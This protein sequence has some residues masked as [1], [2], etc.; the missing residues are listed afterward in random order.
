MQEVTFKNFTTEYKLI[1]Q[2]TRTLLV[3]TV[4]LVF[5]PLYPLMPGVGGDYSWM[6]GM[7]Q[8]VVEKF[9]F[10]KD[11]VFPLGPYASVYTKTYHPGTDHL[12]LLGGLILGIFNSII[13]LKLTKHKSI[14]WHI[15]FIAFFSAGM[16]SRDVLLFMYPLLL[17]L[18]IFEIT[19]LHNNAPRL[20]FQAKV[21][22][23]FLFIPLGLL[24]LIKGSLLVLILG[25]TGMTALLFWI[26]NMKKLA[27]TICVIPVLS[28][29]FFAWVAKQPI[30]GLFYYIK[31]MLDVTSGYTEAMSVNG[32]TAELVL[33]LLTAMMFVYFSYKAKHKP[34]D[35]RLFLT[36][37][38]SLYLF[39]SFKA[40]FARHD[41]HALTSAAAV[42]TAGFLLHT[43]LTHKGLMIAFV[44]SAFTWVFISYNY[45]G[46]LV[47]DVFKPVPVL[48]TES[49]DGLMTRLAEGDRLNEKYNNKLEEIRQMPPS[50]P[51]LQGTVDLYSYEQ[52]YLLAT[53]NK[54]SPRP[55]IQSYAVYTPKLAEMN[56][57][58][59]LSAA[60]PANIIFRLQTID[61][62][63][64]ALDDGLSWP[65]IINNYEPGNIDVGFLYLKQIRQK[66]IPPKKIEV[67][68][69][70]CSLG[71]EV[72]VPVDMSNMLFAEFDIR[73]TV[74]GGLVTALYQPEPMEIIVTLMDGSQRT[75][76]MIPGMSKS[77]FVLSPFVE[78]IDEFKT[79]FSNPSGL[80][81]KA[82]KS[83]KISNEG[84]GFRKRFRSWKP[85]YTFRLSRFEYDK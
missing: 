47:L 13:L 77:G 31:G 6:F 38:I 56:E 82:V 12:M 21:V 17:A 41:S 45:V 78:N 30:T 69:A 39:I 48:Y 34:L 16:F 3:L 65:T 80:Q 70:K 75:H 60:A 55:I 85:V 57:K 20:N 71:Q 67:F 58:H 51:L 19:P 74:I 46:Q 33:Y 76:R 73:Q 68:Q 61:N 53:E 4:L 27:V 11:V 7:N 66:N 81:Q 15:L 44:L 35:L 43:V 40:G 59:L 1:R 9:V 29:M 54:W 36:T 84:L 52:A 2:I 42:F 37:Y 28:T 10:G 14:V 72:A 64:P 8:A 50:I 5:I 25:V 32:R 23:A 18:Y 22:C 62:R 49:M 24:L 26:R 79:L 83:F 63:I